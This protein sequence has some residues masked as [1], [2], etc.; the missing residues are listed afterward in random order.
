MPIDFSQE[1]AKTVAT[2][3]A[4]CVL[5][6]LSGL[7]QHRLKSTPTIDANEHTPHVSV[8]LTADVDI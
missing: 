1:P 8:T 2:V 3:L 4:Q 5:L 7:V 6:L